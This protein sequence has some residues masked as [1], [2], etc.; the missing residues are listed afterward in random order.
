MSNK[1]A[2]FLMATLLGASFCA[3]EASAAVTV[4]PASIIPVQSAK[5]H[6]S[7]LQEAKVTVN[8][9]IGQGYNRR[10]H[11]SRCTYRRGNCNYYYNGYYYQNRW[12]L[13]PSVIGGAII[14]NEI[15]R[16][17]YSNYHVR[18]CMEQYR[19]YDARTNTWISNSGQIRQCNSPY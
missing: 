8:I 10:Y 17:R 12:W 14:G 1:Y 7:L 6:N 15:R 9:G 13:V 11:G 19:S 4:P 5:I 18:W 16:A 2:S 3:S